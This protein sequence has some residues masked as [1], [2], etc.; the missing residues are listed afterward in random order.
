[1]TL[2]N[3]E[4]AI[5]CRQAITAYSDDDSRTNL[6]DFLAD[7]MHWCQLDGHDFRDAI[8]TAQM[9]FNAE[10]TGDDI[11]DDLDRE[12]DIDF[13]ALLAK[14]RQVAVIWSTEDVQ[15]IR[16]DLTDEQAW[17]VLQQCRRFH[18]CEIGFN[19]LLIETVADDM[20][21]KQPLTKE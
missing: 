6:V 13:H 17:E 15:G 10:S 16:S 2:S 20:F 21:P 4:R 9:H 11:L 3:Q 12:A 19:W 18:D 5:R 14:R 7:S 1:M 8:D